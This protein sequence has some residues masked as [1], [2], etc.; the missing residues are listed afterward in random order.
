MAVQQQCRRRSGAVMCQAG[1]Y[2]GFPRSFPPSHTHSS[3]LPPTPRSFPPSCTLSSVPPSVTHPLLGPS[4][5]HAPTPRSLPPSCTLTSVPSPVTHPLLGPFLPHA[6]SP[7]S[8]PP[9]CTHSSVLHTSRTHS[10]VPPSITHL[11]PLSERCR[12]ERWQICCPTAS[13]R[14][15]S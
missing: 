5:P 10:S 2:T 7:G 9:S 1:Q 4:L 14:C 6:P 3:V 13:R 12:E 8:L 11:L 15:P